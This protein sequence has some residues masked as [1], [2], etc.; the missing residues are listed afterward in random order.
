MA[1]S[2]AL[3]HVPARSVSVAAACSSRHLAIVLILYYSECS[4]FKHMAVFP[5]ICLGI[6]VGLWC[7]S[8]LRL[9]DKMVHSA[10][11]RTLIISQSSHKVSAT[12]ENQNQNQFPFKERYKI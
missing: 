6:V 5:Y 3:R 10:F 4:L 9:L 8:E 2:V 1:S 12:V 7:P 11:L